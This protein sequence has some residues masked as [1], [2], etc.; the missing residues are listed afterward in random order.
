MRGVSVNVTGRAPGLDAVTLARSAIA[1]DTRA[2]RRILVGS[3]TVLTALV[4]GAIGACGSSSSG[5]GVDASPSPSDDGASGVTCYNLLSA[6]NVSVA[7][8]D[9]CKVLASGVP[10]A[11]VPAQ[12]PA[13]LIVSKYCDSVCRSV[14]GDNFCV[15]DPT[16]VAAYQQANQPAAMDGG[17][18]G[19]TEGGASGGSPETCPDAPNAGGVR[20]TCYAEMPYQATACPK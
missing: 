1:G 2:M 10:G 15:V 13:D 12:G 17:T 18:E 6:G 4:C 7:S 11:M 16:F 19:G 9:A 3:I 14:H 5:A 8:A 20:I